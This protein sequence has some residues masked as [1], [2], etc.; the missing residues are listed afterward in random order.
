MNKPLMR[1]GFVLL[2]LS[3]LAALVAPQAQIPRLAVSAHSIGFM[4]GI[5]LFAIGAGWSAFSL[6]DRQKNLLKW[7]WIWA[8][9]GNW[10]GVSIASQTGATDLLQINGG[11]PDAPI[12]ATIIVYFFM[13]TIMVAALT[14]SVLGVMG[15]K[16]ED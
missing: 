7:S 8:N 9:F 1:L 11:A 5:M 16:K 14:G 2:L 15:L 12:W 3:L 13:I 4:G 10:A 6:S